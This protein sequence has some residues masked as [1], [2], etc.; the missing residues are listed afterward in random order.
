MK[1]GDTVL[2]NR[3]IQPLG[4][5]KNT[6][7]VLADNMSPNSNGSIRWV[8]ET[9]FP[10]RD[11]GRVNIILQGDLQYLSY[12]KEELLNDR[13]LVISERED[14]LELQLNDNYRDL[15]N[16]KSQSKDN[17]NL[18]FEQLKKIFKYIPIIK[19]GIKG[20][21]NEEIKCGVFAEATKSNHINP[22]ILK[23]TGLYYDSPKPVKEVVNKLKYNFIPM[24]P[25]MVTKCFSS[26]SLLENCK[27]KVR[28]W[29]NSAKFFAYGEYKKGLV[30]KFVEASKLELQVKVKRSEELQDTIYI[31]GED[32]NT[33]FLLSDVD[34][35]YPNIKGLYPKKKKVVNPGVQVRLVNDNKINYAK[36]N[37]VLIVQDMKVVGRN[38]RPNRDKVFL[39][40]KVKDKIIYEDSRKFKFYK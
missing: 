33:R 26:A 27:F 29:A 3:Y 2:I 6:I 13:V 18:S 22:Y 16:N 10:I 23:G 19:N 25:E 12:T 24:T 17:L 28:D 9:L 14:Q 11:R 36:K 32:R 4:L 35:M 15:P 39:G 21:Y 38:N 5:R 31:Q 34:I 1:V 7:C 30:G 8:C 40:F 37:D 20:F